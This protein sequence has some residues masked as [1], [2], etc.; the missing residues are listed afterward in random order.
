MDPELKKTIE[1]A[2]REFDKDNSNTIERNE[3]KDVAQKLGEELSEQEIDQ[4]FKDIDSDGNK[5]ISLEEFI[6]WWQYGKLNQMEKLLKLKL[7][8]GSI[9]DRSKFIRNRIT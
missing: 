1:Q 7:K 5:R 2:F 4:I 3:I 8:A 6:N 9:A